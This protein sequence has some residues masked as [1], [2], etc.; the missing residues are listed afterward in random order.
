[1]RL[2]YPDKCVFM[3]NQKGARFSSTT[4]DTHL[5]AWI[6]DS[7]WLSSGDPSFDW[8]DLKNMYVANWQ[9][10]C[11]DVVNPKYLCILMAYFKIPDLHWWINVLVI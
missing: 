2:V 10:S 3:Y 4:N 11:I 8:G 5:G 7:L 6:V 9:Y 1:M